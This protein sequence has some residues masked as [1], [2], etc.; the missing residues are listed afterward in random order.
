MATG[1]CFWSVLAC[2]V[3]VSPALVMLCACAQT[4]AYGPGVT[5]ERETTVGQRPTATAS[6]MGPTNKETT[7]SPAMPSRE[8]A[9]GSPES[10]IT[11]GIRPG[12]PSI[13]ASPGKIKPAPGAPGGGIMGKDERLGEVYIVKKGD[14]LWK[15]AGKSSTLGHGSR[16]GAIYKANKG[17]VRD[18]NMIYPGQELRI[19]V[20]DISVKT[21]SKSPQ[22]QGGVKKVKPPSP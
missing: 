6:T 9:P 19:P 22:K 17:E 5:S 20:A 18:P 1:K 8:A 7:I 10:P 11:P 15:I 13:P 14:C 16:W 3:I 4:G 12:T 2:G 21:T